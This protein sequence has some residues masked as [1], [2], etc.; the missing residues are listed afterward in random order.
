MN[1]L[2]IDYGSKKI[3]LA[4]A[5]VELKIATPFKILQNSPRVFADLRQII[6]QEE[7]DE[8]VVGYPLTLKGETGKQAQAVEKFIKKMSIFNLPIS[9]QDERF[10]SRGAVGSKFGN[11]ASAAAL[12]LQSYLDVSL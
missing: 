1:Y 12:I 3:G 8:L 6:K 11:D 5:A 10:S 9:R 7:I 4:K 2:A